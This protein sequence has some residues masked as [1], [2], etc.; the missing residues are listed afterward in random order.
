MYDT[1]RQKVI[2]KYGSINKLAKVI[3]VSAQDLYCAFGGKKPFYPKW[4]MLV[5]EAI[6]EDESV[7]FGEEW[8]E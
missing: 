3:D 6:G 1:V 2:E 5:A 7:V 4:R 8:K